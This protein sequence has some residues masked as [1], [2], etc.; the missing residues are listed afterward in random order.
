MIIFM[1]YN[2]KAKWSSQF[3]NGVVA[4]ILEGLTM[5]GT[6]GTVIIGK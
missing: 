3:S 5:N 4:W 6:F 1:A 2:L